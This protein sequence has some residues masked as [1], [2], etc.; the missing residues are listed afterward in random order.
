[1]EL[2]SDMQECSFSG[3][4]TCCTNSQWLCSFWMS[5][6]SNNNGDPWHNW[7]CCDLTTYHQMLL[8]MVAGPLW[9][10]QVG[11]IALWRTQADV[12]CSC[13][14]QWG[15]FWNAERGRDAFH[16]NQGPDMPQSTASRLRGVQGG[17]GK[18]WIFSAE[19]ADGK[20][21]IFAALWEILR[22]NYDPQSIILVVSW[23]LSSAP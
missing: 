22:M 1:M 5:A 2:R 13:R 11:F 21:V 4:R 6:N 20:D 18:G 23:C 14:Q 3:S 17:G 9:S 10:L 8:E 12:T 7:G 19:W 15:N 16:P